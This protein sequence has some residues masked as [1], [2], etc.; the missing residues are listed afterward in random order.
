MPVPK[1]RP[2]KMRQ[3]HRKAGHP[4]LA[5]PTFSRCSRCRQLVLSHRVCWNCGHYQGRKVA[6][7]K[8]L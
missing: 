3:R 4:K 2:S 8:T 1:H 6:D 7:P 5:A